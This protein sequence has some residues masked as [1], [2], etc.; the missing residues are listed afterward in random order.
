MM[1]DESKDKMKKVMAEPVYKVVGE[2][3]VEAVANEELLSEGSDVPVGMSEET[4]TAD[5]EAVSLK[6]SEQCEEDTEKVKKR[7]KE[8]RKNQEE[9]T[10]LEKAIMDQAQEGEKKDSRNFSL[11]KILAGDM[12]SAEVLRNNI[13]LIVLI[14][15]FMIV[16]VTNRYTAQKY[17]I[18]IDKLN[19]QLD[20]AKYKAL[21]SS[22]QLTEK[23]RESHIL[24]L[25]KN[26]KDSVLKISDRPPYI[27][28][29]PE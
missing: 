15:V 9:I 29:V 24:E 3:D 2:P 8:E 14:V 6:D 26:N 22:S 7:A 21:A 16:Y 17:L 10:L 13:G 20:D 1:T 12:L 4:A 27:I 18:E 23:T 19:T 11:T 25:L 5:V 28:N